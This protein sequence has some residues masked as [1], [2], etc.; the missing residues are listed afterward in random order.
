MLLEKVYV[1]EILKRREEKSLH[2]N[3]HKIPLYYRTVGNG[4]L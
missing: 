2:T 4:S 1:R 3:G